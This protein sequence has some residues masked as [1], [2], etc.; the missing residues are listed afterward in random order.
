MQHPQHQK[1]FK[2]LPLYISEYKK[3]FAASQNCIF[4]KNHEELSGSA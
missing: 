2:L 3:I 1:R 4:Q